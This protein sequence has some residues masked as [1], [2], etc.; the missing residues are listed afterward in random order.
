[1]ACY[2][3]GVSSEFN[4]GIKH[5]ANVKSVVSLVLSFILMCY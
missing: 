2:I 1:M 5:D 3:S 4:Y